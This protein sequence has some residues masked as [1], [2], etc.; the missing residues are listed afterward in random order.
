MT[1]RRYVHV[2][3][4]PDVDL[5]CLCGQDVPPIIATPMYY[6]VSVHRHDMFFLATVCAEVGPC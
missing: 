1:R 2:L 5:R 6:L 3:R 4:S